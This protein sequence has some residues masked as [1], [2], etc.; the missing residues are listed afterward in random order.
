M[1]GLIFTYA[2]TYGGAVVSLLNPFYGL[3]AYVCFAIICPESLW[4]WAVPQGGHYSR[5]VAIGFLAGWALHGFG[6]WRLGRAG[7]VTLAYF[8]FWAWAAL[9]ALLV[10]TDQQRAFQFLEMQAKTLLPFVAGIT[11]IDSAG[12][13]KVL[14]WTI[15]LS[16]G[17]VAYEMNL[18]YWS[19]FNRVQE[20]G[21]GG[22][23]NNCVAIAMVAGAGLAF[24]M[25]LHE[26]VFWRKWLAFV[27]A[28]LM[29]HTIMIAFSRGGML[30]LLLSGVISLLL[31]DKA[32]PKHYAYL[33]LAVFV[34]LYM[35][36]SEVRE[37]FWS[38]FAD[39]EV[40]DA[41]A[42]ERADMWGQCWILMQESPLLGVG[43]DNWVVYANERF[44][45]GSH[46]EAHSLW[47]QTGAELGFPGLAFL[48]AFYGLA[49]IRLWPI[50]KR[51]VASA[52]EW[53]VTVARMTI[54]GLG[55]FAIAAQFVS[56]EGL[57]L[58]YY[59]TLVGAGTLKLSASRTAESP[60]R[61]D[62]ATRV[63]AV[64]APPSPLGPP[65]SSQPNA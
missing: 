31:I 18:A 51:R 47:L 19:G 8:A 30:A 29:A 44:G 9:S 58:P 56:L 37:R 39:P 43:P 52:S 48:V 36:G 62:E 13:L 57:E 22:M 24:F 6:N 65:D 49:C 2:V 46:K 64:L 1:K 35:A 17:F 42:Q 21:F 38:A 3:L 10:A 26:K 28:G 45:W 23:D 4:Y 41:S 12:K 20:I 14:A 11:L 33:L 32:K 50:A 34:A 25:G 61:V 7:G 27:C 5:I 63:A 53:D 40:R 60:A 59:I 54:A 55:G 16:Q 15:L